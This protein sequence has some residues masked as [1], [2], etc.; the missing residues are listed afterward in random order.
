MRKRVRTC[1]EINSMA[2]RLDS[3]SDCA[4]YRMASTSKRCPSTYRGSEVRSRF[5]RFKLGG[6]GMVKTLAIYSLA[7]ARRTPAIRIGDDIV[8]SI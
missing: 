7:F 8:S 2:G 1:S 6:T 4:R 5:L 3:G